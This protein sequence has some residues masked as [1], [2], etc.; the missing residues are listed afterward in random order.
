MSDE[1]GLTHLDEQGAARMVDVG[2][3]PDTQREAVAECFV[4]L[5]P[6]TVEALRAATLAKGD[7]LQVARIAGIMGMKRTPDLIPLCHPIAIT[8][9]NVDLDLRDDGAR[10]EASA[11]FHGKTG[12]EME[13]MTGAVVTALTLIDMVKGIERGVEIQRVRLLSKTGG[14]SGDWTAEEG[15]VS[16]PRS[17]EASR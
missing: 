16:P 8:G 17:P 1:T 7:A 15:F 3:K 4:P 10:I 13:A 14:K 9:T 12:V 5:K 2:Q 6:A 11:R